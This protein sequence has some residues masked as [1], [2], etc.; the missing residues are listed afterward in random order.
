VLAL[1]LFPPYAQVGVAAAIAV[2][3]WVGA[4]IL[5]VLL[6]RRGWLAFDKQAGRRIPAILLATLAMGAAIMGSD[7]LMTASFDVAA[8]SLSRVTSLVVLVLFG[9]AVYLAALRAL[10]VV[11]LRALFRDARL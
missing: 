4:S 2:S 10:G 5:A 11:R 1:V 6:W 8:S 9:L 3:G 7:A